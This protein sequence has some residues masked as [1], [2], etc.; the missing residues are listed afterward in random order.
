[1]WSTDS[2]SLLLSE[3]LHLEWKLLE[4][5]SAIS[6]KRDDVMQSM[7]LLKFSKES[8]RA[9]QPGA[10]SAGSSTLRQAIIFDDGNQQSLTSS[11]LTSLL[12]CGI[13]PFGNV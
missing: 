3:I 4:S 1:M 5:N 9:K 11:N 6:T 7:L 8:M 10:T 13:F 2:Q 12:C